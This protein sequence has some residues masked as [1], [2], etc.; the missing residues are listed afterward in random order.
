[1]LRSTLQTTV[2]YPRFPNFYFHMEI[3][4]TAI[5]LGT[6][7]LSVV[8]TTEN[9]FVCK[10][11]T[12]AILQQVQEKIWMDSTVHESFNMISP[13]ID[14]SSLLSDLFIKDV[15]RTSMYGG[16]QCSSDA[17]NNLP[18]NHHLRNTSCPF[19]LV[20]NRDPNRIPA[21]LM[22]ARCNCNRDETCIG[23]DIKSRCAPIKYFVRA[24]RKTALCGIDGYYEYR[25]TLEPITVGCTCTQE[26]WTYAGNFKMSLE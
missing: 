17:M 22:E 6:I 20:M 7:L 19:H 8:C 12:P 10:N 5:F 18:G 16:R 15:R 23:G 1:M 3:Q 14:S 13:N 2:E 26:H 11:L 24:M 21:I 4:M 25:H 9:A